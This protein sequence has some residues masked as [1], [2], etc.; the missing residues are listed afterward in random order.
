VESTLAVARKCEQLDANGITIYLFSSRFKRYDNVTSDKVTQIFQE[1]F[2]VGT[3]V[4][5]A[6]KRLLQTLFL[7]DEKASQ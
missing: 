3:L 4:P 5:E 7:S 1:K 6:L 2:V